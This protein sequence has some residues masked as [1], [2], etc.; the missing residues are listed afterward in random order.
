MVDSFIFTNSD[1]S[2]KHMTQWPQFSPG[3]KKKKVY[4]NFLNFD[5]LFATLPS[6]F[7][8]CLLSEN[9]NFRQ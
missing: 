7:Q 6:K 8:Y 4:D 2:L 9:M 5:S 3:K 1:S